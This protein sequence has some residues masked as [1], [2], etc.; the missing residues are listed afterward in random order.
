MAPKEAMTLG[1]SGI[2]LG[3][4]AGWVLGPEASGCSG[5]AG[6]TVST[7]AQFSGEEKTLELH[8]QLRDKLFN[9]QL[10]LE[11]IQQ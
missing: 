8:Q 9:R 4:G 3:K 7:S 2:P 11:Q 6:I 1:V 10:S 5:P